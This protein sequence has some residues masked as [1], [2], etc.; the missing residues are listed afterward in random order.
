MAY[1]KCS[2]C[3]TPHELF[4]SAASFQNASAELQLPVLGE[5][6]PKVDGKCAV[7]IPG[8]LPL[9]TSVSDGGDAGR[10]VMIQS[11]KEGDEVR[12]VMRGV[13]EGVWNWLDRHPAPSSIGARG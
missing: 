10:P 11:G 13:S 6:T 3:D 12:Q 9:V 8:E 7:L 5:C 2:S 4:G 1:F